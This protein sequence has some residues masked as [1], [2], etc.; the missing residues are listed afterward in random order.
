MDEYQQILLEENKKAAPVKSRFFLNRVKFLGHIIEF[1][2]RTPL[3]SRL[4]A[5]LKLQSPSNKT[6]TQEFFGMLNFLSK[7]V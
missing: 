3:N 2:L 7:Y 5:I 4:H 6:K 1:N